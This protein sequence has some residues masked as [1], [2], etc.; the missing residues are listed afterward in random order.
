MQSALANVEGVS[1]V[2]VDK[3]NS[4]ATVLLDRNKLSNDQL[5]A[6]LKKSNGGKYGATVK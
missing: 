1:K 6:A 4:T 2:T 3:G 5:I